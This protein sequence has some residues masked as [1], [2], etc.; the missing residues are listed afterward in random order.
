MAFS[1]LESV[2]LHLPSLIHHSDRGVQY[3]SHDY[4]TLLKE[5]QINISMTQN[6]NPLENAIAE[7][8]NSIIKGEYLENYDIAKI[9]DAKALLKDVVAL[10]NN[11][12]P[13]MSIGNLTPNQVYHSLNKIK[14]EKL[15]KNY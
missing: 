14:P 7:R 4:V 8:I 6:G 5:R 9:D 15:W 1:E 12:R 11:E 13:H 10:Y 3:C 2:K